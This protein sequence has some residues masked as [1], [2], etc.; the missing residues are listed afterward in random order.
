M[1]KVDLRHAYR[2]VPVHPSNYDALGLKWHFEGDSE[3]SYLVDTRLPFGGKSAP[4]IFHRLTQAVKRMMFRRGF[5]MVVVYL[6]D[7]LVLGRSFADCQL[8][9][10]TISALLV[11]LGFTLSPSKLVPPT[12]RLT[13]LGVEID[14]CTLSLSLP[15]AKLSELSS[16]VK[17]FLCR[18]QATKRQL[19]R[20]AGKLNWACKV[21]YGGR[22]FLRRVLD[23]MNSLPFSRSLCRLSKDFHADLDWWHAFLQEFNGKC[24]FLDSRPVTSLHTDACSSALG[25]SFGSDWFYSKL[26]VDFPEL[27]SLHINFKEAICVVL[28]VLRWAPCLR[29]KRVHVF[30][31]NTAAVAMLNKGTTRSPIMMIYLRLLFW[32]SAVFNFRLRAFHVPGVEN[33]YADHISRLHEASHLST[34]VSLLSSPVLDPS[35]IDCFRHMSHLSYFLLLNLYS[36]SISH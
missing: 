25:A 9:Y 35:S 34:F 13:F 28:S 16:V 33:S 10:D 5:P 30:C 14:S 8:A 4:G 1:A 26:H 22:T 27:V 6:D 12:Q 18:K 7:F 23:L 15:L 21:V 20:L 24:D 11:D 36:T 29:N 17:S 32:L 3:I 19:Q 31:D 2:S